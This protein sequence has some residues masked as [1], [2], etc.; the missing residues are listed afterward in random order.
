MS[1]T[2]GQQKPTIPPPLSN[3]TIANMLDSVAELLDA[4]NAN[5]YRVQAYRNAATTLRRLKSH[6]G[7]ILEK[8]GVPG[9]IQ[10]P[11]IGRSIAHAID[12]ILQT[13][14]LNLLERLRGST[15]PEQVL[16][17]VP[18]IGPKLASRIHETL[19]IE[20][21]PELQAAAYDGRLDQVPGFGPQRLRAVRESIAGRLHPR[22]VRRP[23]LPPEEQPAIE[24]L[25]S[26][27]QEYRQK[28]KAREIPLIAPRRFNPTNEA[29][30]PI[31]HTERGDTHYTALYSNTARAHELNMIRDW[32]VIY[33][34]DADGNGQW[35]IITSQFGLLR[36]RRIIRGREAECQAHYLH[37]V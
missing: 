11:G 31:L 21:L 3:K 32:V 12:Q 19:D 13:G 30:L 4:Q 20:T 34:D 25:L 9:L 2:N 26:V 17:T 24:D 36:G 16:A 5:P 29:W 14:K 7:K 6:V 18:T 22:P 1:K 8:E 27:D 37:A 15:M 35:T 10:L 28:A 33:R 23:T